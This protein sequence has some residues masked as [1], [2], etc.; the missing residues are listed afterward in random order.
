MA[1]N[2]SRSEIRREEEEKKLRKRLYKERIEYLQTQVELEI[3]KKLVAR[4]ER[5][6]IWIEHLKKEEAF[7]TKPELTQKDTESDKQMDACRCILQ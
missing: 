7:R 3:T 2:R 6:R 5:N 4:E 1:H